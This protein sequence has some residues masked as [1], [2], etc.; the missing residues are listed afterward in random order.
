MAILRQLNLSAGVLQSMDEFSKELDRSNTASVKWELIQEVD[1]PEKWLTTSCY[2]GEDRT[3]PMWVADM[4][5]ASP[6]FVQE[7]IIQRAQHGIYGYTR[8]DEAYLHAV[9]GW[10]E[11][12][13]GWQ[14]KPSWIVVCPG[15]VPAL[16]MAI[17]ALA[18]SG[19]KVLV[20]RPVYYPFFSAVSSNSKEIVSSSL[21]L[22]NGV[23]KMD[24]DDM[25]AK[26][27]DSDTKL[28]I[29]CNPHNPVGRV[30]TVDELLIFGRLC[31]DHGVTVIADEIHGDLIM[32]GHKFTPFASLED[33]SDFT[34]TCTAP[35]KTFNL[36]GLQTSNLLIENA[37]LRKKVEKV[38]RDNGLMGVNLFGLTAC[39]AAYDQ[40]EPWLERLLSLFGA[41]LDYL[42]SFFLKNLPQLKMFRPEGT[43]L[44]WFDCRQAESDHMI[45]RKKIM[46]EA[47]L[48][49]DDGFIFG[50]EGRGFQR[51]NFACPKPVLEEAM[52]RL[53]RVFG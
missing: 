4:D 37:G 22:C 15:V 39:Q 29:L 14:V 2:F 5:F 35:S 45:L 7:A 31:R 46:K 8:A 11:R 20:Q 16:H 33:F 38:L 18:D 10:M 12:R 26:L 53:Q 30:W 25:E 41:H 23:Y 28:A 34:I 27:A 32:A 19:S 42:E 44:L 3:L 43:Y 17:R 52:S 48:F 36:A 9:T 47:K 40:G 1:N 51:L 21:V 6:K 49:L 24:F 50:D 13:H